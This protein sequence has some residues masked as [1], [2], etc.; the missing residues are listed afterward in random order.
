MGSKKI[1]APAPRDYRQEM[2]DAMSAQEAIQPRLLALEQ[3]Y[4]PLYQQLQQ[5]GIA[6]GMGSIANLYGQA[7]QLTG[8][9]QR[10]V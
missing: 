6:S 1:K 2:M 7:G 9:L 5:Q 4:T 3:Q 10:Q 8:G